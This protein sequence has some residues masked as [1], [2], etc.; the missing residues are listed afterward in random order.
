ML[1]FYKNNT[2]KNPKSSNHT[3]FVFKINTPILQYSNIPLGI[4]SWQSQFTLIQP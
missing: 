1:F 2:L 3:L 4:I